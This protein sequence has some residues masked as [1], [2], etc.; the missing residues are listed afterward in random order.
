[1]FETRGS[2]GMLV[3]SLRY[4]HKVAVAQHRSVYVVI[5]N[6]LQT[7]RLCYEPECQHAVTDPVTQDAYQASFGHQVQITASVPAFG[8][9]ASGSPLPNVNTR[10][11]VDNLN[12]LTQAL[13][14]QVE[15]DTGYVRQ[16]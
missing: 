3:S 13:T 5:D 16:L 7:L 1:V 2:M 8:F 10:Y 11:V 14:V 9:S 6:T 15:A 12:Q 4:A